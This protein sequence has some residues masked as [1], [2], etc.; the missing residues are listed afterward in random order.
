M[1]EGGIEGGSLEVQ[2]LEGQE[3]RERCREGGRM[4]GRVVKR[5]FVAPLRRY[6][7]RRGSAE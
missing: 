7:S 2:T 3:E 1:R 5:E 4:A 6:S